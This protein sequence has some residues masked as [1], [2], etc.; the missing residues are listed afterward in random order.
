MAKGKAS[1][2]HQNALYQQYKIDNRSQKNRTERLK[3]HVNKHPN[4]DQAAKVLSKGVVEYRR[5]KPMTK[6]W[7]SPMRHMAQIVKQAGLKGDIVL[8]WKEKEKKSQ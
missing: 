5:K 3:R 4:D 7:S 8:K 2:K 6:K 1:S